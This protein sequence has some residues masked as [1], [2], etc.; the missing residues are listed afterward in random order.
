MIWV[1][2]PTGNSFVRALLKR[3][4][5]ED[6]DFCYHTTLGF[7]AQ[8][9]SI[10]LLPRF[11]KRRLIRRTYDVPTERLR[12]KPLRDLVRLCAARTQLAFLTAHETGPCSIDA[13]YRG[14][15]KAV[16]GR[17]RRL[18]M[19][20]CTDMVVY[21][22]E[23]GCSA[24][25]AVAKKLGIRCVYDLPIAYWETSRKLLGEEAER[26][27]EWEP[28]LIGTRDS[29]LKLERKFTELTNADVIVC[30]SEFVYRSLPEEV[31]STKP[32]VVA[33]FGSPGPLQRE[34]RSAEVSNGK[35]RVLFAGSMTQ[36]K[37]LADLFAA[38]RL[39]KRSDVELIVMGSLVAPMAFY[40]QQYSAFQY[41]P[42]RSHAAVLSLMQ[43]CDVLVLPSIVEGRALV[44]QEALSCGL[45]LIVTANAGGEDLVEEGQ[46]GFLVP[47][48]SPHSIASRI[49]WFADHREE[50]NGM[51]QIARQKAA[52]YTWDAYGAKLLQAMAATGQS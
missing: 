2:H 48:R 38:M 47:I 33:Q 26:L 51:R 7:S 45:P 16:A 49:A 11:L 29:S 8:A 34:N 31:R 19:S 17:L 43:Q 14:L 50:L 23:D 12:T 30:P 20:A 52:Q 10:K 41:E 5:L 6:W 25:F 40:R 21:G 24:S 15:D 1:A 44:Q 3:L 9:R 13:V 35:L 46:T 32:C 22:Y 28:T 27:P 4:V 18:G 36:R 42:P 39:L 37:G